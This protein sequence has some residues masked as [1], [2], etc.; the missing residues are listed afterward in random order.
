MNTR[1]EMK[2][3]NIQDSNYPKRESNF[4]TTITSE[5]TFQVIIG[6]DGS[7]TLLLWQ[8]EYYMEAYLSHCELPITLSKVDSVIFLKWIKDNPQE[9]NF[10][11]HPVFGQESPKLGFKELMGKIIEK[12]ESDGDFYD[13]L[14]ENNL[15]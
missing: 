9:L 14:R 10:F 5:D 11:I 6:N 1:V 7:S 13:T 2:K 8:D 4:L 15:L 3:Q 12:M